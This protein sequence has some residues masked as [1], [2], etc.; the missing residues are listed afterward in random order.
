MK[1]WSLA[2]ILFSLSAFAG[3]VKLQPY[4]P[5]PYANDPFSLAAECFLNDFDG[6]VWV[7]TCLYGS[8]DSQYGLKHAI[9]TWDTAGAPLTA[10]PCYLYANQGSPV[11]PAKVYGKFAL[12]QNKYGSIQGI[13]SAGDVGFMLAGT[14]P[15]L[16]TP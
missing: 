9:I 7:G 1:A 10:T 15:V 11:C 13:D 16:L 3:E 12:V 4:L 5:S 6:T 14:V 2:L 8:G